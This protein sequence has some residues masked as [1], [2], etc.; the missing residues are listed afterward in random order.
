MNWREHPKFQFLKQEIEKYINQ[1]EL[2]GTYYIANPFDVEQNSTKI[3]R[4]PLGVIAL[5]HNIPF[6]SN[7]EIY[8]EVEKRFDLSFRIGVGFDRG[9]N[10]PN[11]PFTSDNRPCDEHFIGQEIASFCLENN[12]IN[13]NET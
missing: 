4:C 8:E 13:S 9:I 7:E 12:W 11:S 1:G 2:L 3:R 10:F 6:S 5:N